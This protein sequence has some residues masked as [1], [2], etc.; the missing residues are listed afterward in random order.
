[1]SNYT[2]A[3]Q[4]L[5]WL[6]RRFRGV[7][8]LIPQLEALSSLENA[9][10]EAHARLEQLQSQ[11]VDYLSAVAEA[12]RALEA[13]RKD[14]E[15]ILQETAAEVARIKEEAVSEAR[16]VKEEASAAIQA[17]TEKAQDE[18]KAIAKAIASRKNELAKVVEEHD[19]ALARLASIKSEIESLK[20][21]F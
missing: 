4:D 17:E 16:R 20:A 7:V 2:A 8:E 19:Q 5:L 13:S 21:R 3:T 6:A 1:M 9:I 10:N 12:E 14:R 18:R 15:A 11:H